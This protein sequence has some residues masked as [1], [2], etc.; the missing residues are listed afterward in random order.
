MK[1]ARRWLLLVAALWLLPQAALAQPKKPAGGNKPPP[2]APAAGGDIEI[3]DP[4]APA[5]EEQPAEPAPTPTEE[6]GAGGG[7]I[8]EIDPS[9][10][11]KQ[12][13]I[14]KLADRQVAADVY[15]VQQIYALRRGR[16][17]INPYWSQ[18]LNDQFVG[19]PGPGLAVNYYL[20]NVLAVGVNGTYYQP[21]NSDADFNFENRRATRLAVPLNE[22]LGGYAVNFTY[23]PMYGKFSGFGN[24][25]FH[26]GGFGGLFTRPIAVID[27][28]NR[29]FDFEHR[30]AF[31]VGFGLRIFLN[32]WFSVI[33]EI[34]DYIYIEQLEN[35]QVA[36][37]QAGQQDRN[38]WF[39]EKPLTNNVQAQIGISMFLPF[40]WEY[41]LPK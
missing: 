6:T 39:G 31:N 25:I 28:D 5:H 4:N 34:R 36:A 14:K 40:S 13:D 3:D 15:A 7:G 33:G 20:T 19:H 23:V 38:T 2:T 16:F 37:T 18:S 30:I 1:H 17:E 9:A 41:R 32:R 35:T 24:F 12:G 22:Y 10:C 26:Y 29:K 8:C 21:F 27:P 11:P